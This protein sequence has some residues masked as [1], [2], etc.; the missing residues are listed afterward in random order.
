MNCEQI[1]TLADKITG[2]SSIDEAAAISLASIPHD[3]LPCLF[4][5]ASR[6]REHFFGNSVSLCA[7][8]N[9]KSGRCPEDCAFCA[10]SAHHSTSAAVYPL[11]DEADIISGASAAADAGASCY[12][13]VTSGS[14]IAPGAELDRLCSVIKEIRKA[15]IIAPSASLGTINSETAAILRQAGLVTYHHNLE[16]ARSFFP[17]ICST[18]D[19]EDDVETVRVAKE[20][21]F[22]VCSGGIF[23]LG[24]SMEQ[25][26]EMAFTLK[27]LGV[28]SVPI[29]F[30]DP[31]PGT[32]MDSATPLTPLECLHT[33]AIFRFILPEAHI[34]VC[35]GREKNLRELQSWIFLAGAS[36]MMTGN[37]LTK[38]G[39]QPETDRR[40]IE[41]LGLNIEKEHCCG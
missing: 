24:E 8:V 40:M 28:D 27:G 19:Y 26:V 2:G 11:L 21:G 37:Y 12:G 4:A 34:T 39:R 38:Q 15:G 1:F 23:G 14:G 41:D 3:R 31:V 5:A 6:M 9:A 35:G 29:N 13:I 20:A 30:L 32:P 22:R 10:Q 25:R 17:N 18:H 36:G 7:I 16:T 33:I